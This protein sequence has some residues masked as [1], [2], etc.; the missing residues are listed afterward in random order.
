MTRN[1]PA[2]TVTHLQKQANNIRRRNGSVIDQSYHQPP[3][4]VRN[5]ALIAVTG[6]V[7]IVMFLAVIAGALVMSVLQDD[8]DQTIEIVAQQVDIIDKLIE[9][10]ERREQE[11]IEQRAR[12]DEAR[13]AE[14]SWKIAATY[15]IVCVVFILAAAHQWFGL[16]GVGIALAAMMSIFGIWSGNIVM[17]TFSG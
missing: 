10:D 1:L 16:W 13:D 12:E 4:H 14:S 8:G 17:E 3:W 2:A 5:G 15:W 9:R 11:L 6:G 7:A